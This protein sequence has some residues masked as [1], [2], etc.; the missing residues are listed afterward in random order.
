MSNVCVSMNDARMIPVMRTVAV[1]MAVCCGGV[2]WR[3]VLWWCVCGGVCVQ[4]KKRLNP[5]QRAKLRK[6][7]M[8]GGGG[9]GGGR[10]GKGG[11]GGGRGLYRRVN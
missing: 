1:C 6:Q 10:G 4:F 11:K 9:G 2:L 3:C 5:K 8:A 7:K